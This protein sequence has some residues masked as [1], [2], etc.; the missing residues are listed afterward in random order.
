MDAIAVQV[1][2]APKPQ[3]KAPQQVSQSETRGQAQQKG[4]ALTLRDILAANA[5][6]EGAPQQE[7]VTDG[8]FLA[9]MLQQML[10]M[11]GMPVEGA[12][13][14]DEGLAALKAQLEKD[15]SEMGAQMLMEMLM[16]AG[17]SVSIA[18][19]SELVAQMTG[20]VLPETGAVTAG[21]NAADMIALLTGKQPVAPQPQATEQQP[22]V[23]AQTAVAQ[24][25]A[26]AAKSAEQ[27]GQESALS[28]QAAFQQAILEAQKLLKAE[29][30][31]AKEAAPIDVDQLQSK[32][33][34]SKVGLPVANQ[35][36]AYVGAEA[37]KEA[38]ELK[39][40]TPEE[41]MAQIK[42]G[43][44]AG[45]NTGKEEFVIKLK[46]DG[47]GEIT[48]KMVEAGSHISMSI[49][50]SSTQVQRMIS[51]EL[52]GLREAMKPFGVEV[53]QVTS[54]NPGHFNAEQQNN[55]GGHQHQQFHE[56]H[57][58][59]TWFEGGE[60]GETN[61]EERNDQ[62]PESGSLNTYI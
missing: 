1:Q 58:T 7:V 37:V 8:S 52:A 18:D 25:V 57:A 16:A 53:A 61:P 56:N 10:G 4:E 40:P 43:V 6:A 30:G 60:N 36:P 17:Q 14:P 26:G 20:E 45:M 2:Q 48:V 24:E 49:V 51:S 54:Q 15:G 11:E 31:T 32:V 42:T 46:P 59:S 28:G 50:T 39:L 41:L 29:K 13:L 44:A 35:V 3:P 5:A 62:Q 34:A 21:L 33:D 27:G 9:M 22:V 23:V 47:L 19:I 38:V 55:F 12:L